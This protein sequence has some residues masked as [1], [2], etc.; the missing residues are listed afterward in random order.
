MNHG[1]AMKF[2]SEEDYMYKSNVPQAGMYR[3]DHI[4]VSTYI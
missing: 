1:P 3:W 2:F 4:W